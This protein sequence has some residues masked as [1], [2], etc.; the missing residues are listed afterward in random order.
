M[1]QADL[2][3]RHA[4]S[5]PTA[6]TREI[7]YSEALREAMRQA[8]KA[9]DRVFLLGEDIGVYGGAFGVTQ[10]LIEEFGAERVRDTPIS[11]NA[12]VGRGGGQRGARACARSPRCSS[13]TS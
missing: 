3:P 9:D 10:G 2:R 1:D 11:E 7:S 4:P 13:W 6:G 5:I 12:I 8:L